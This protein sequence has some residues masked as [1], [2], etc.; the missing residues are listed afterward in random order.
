[1]NQNETS[2]CYTFCE[3]T[4]KFTGCQHLGLLAMLNTELLY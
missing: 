1:M 3:E 4:E 2:F